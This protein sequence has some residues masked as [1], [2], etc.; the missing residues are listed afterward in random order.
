MTVL[1]VAKEIWPQKAVLLPEASD[2][3]IEAF[4]FPGAL[5]SSDLHLNVCYVEEGTIKFSSQLLLRQLLI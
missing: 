3:F 1:Y 4:L 5:S 2:V